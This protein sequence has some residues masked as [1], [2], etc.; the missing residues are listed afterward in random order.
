MT[1]HV[2]ADVVVVGSGAGGGTVAGELA[3]A[4]A[5][6]VVVEAGPALTEPP[7]GHAQNR[8]TTEA[9]LPAFARFLEETMTPPSGAPVA[10]S[11]LPGLLVIHAVGGMLTGWTHN[12]PSPDASELPDWMP[13]EKW[14]P[15]LGRARQLLGVRDDLWNGN[16]RFQQILDRVDRLTGPLPRGREAAPMPVAVQPTDTGLRWTGADDLLVGAWA[17]CLEILSGHVVRKVLHEGSRVQGVVAFPATGGEAVTISADAVVLAGGTIGT[18]QLVAASGLDAGPAFG[19]Y[20]MEHVTIAS[21]VLLQE[22]L[23]EADNGGDTAFGGLGIWIP[24]S[25]RHPWHSQLVRHP[26]DYSGTVP[27][28]FAAD[29]TVDVLAMCAV[30]PDPDNAL[31]FDHEHLDPFGLPSVD[32]RIE[33]SARDEQIVALALAEQFQLSAAVGD[34]RGRWASTVLPRGS[35][36]HVMGSCRMGVA[37]DGTSVV[38]ADGGLWRYENCF[39]AGNAVFASANASNPTL[40]TVALALRCADRIGELS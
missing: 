40:T 2:G 21:R 14:A 19:R 15:L 39:V 30:T 22:D 4:G 33:L 23:R 13:A 31:S 20:L 28:G 7:G 17:D 1:R 9:G 34:V 18:A 29:D 38:S 35:S 12:C 8:D 36:T 25:L 3:R 16:D 26:I 11:S 6:V 10:P 24:V 37:D 27:E 5:R 32:G